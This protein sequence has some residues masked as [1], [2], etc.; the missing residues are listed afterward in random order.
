MYFLFCLLCLTRS[1][2]VFCMT[3]I[4]FRIL[5][6]CSFTMPCKT[7]NEKPVLIEN[8]IVKQMVHNSSLYEMIHPKR[9][10]YL[11]LMDHLVFWDIVGNTVRIDSIYKYITARMS[12][13]S[14][15]VH[16]QTQ[17]FLLWQMT[18]WLVLKSFSRRRYFPYFFVC[19]PLPISIRL[20]ITIAVE[21]NLDL[22]MFVDHSA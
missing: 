9:Y 18:H 13:F 16:F 11:F 21:L 10:R 7:N 22:K 19:C 14:L 17:K 2:K 8:Y 5:R 20:L 4:H 6:W 1:T 3:A 15:L 12:T